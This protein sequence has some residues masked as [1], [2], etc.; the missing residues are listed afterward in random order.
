MKPLDHRA[1]GE[2]FVYRAVT[3]ERVVDA[4]RRIAGDEVRLGP[5]KA[6]PGG[7]ATVD[8]TGR[9]GVPEADETAAD[10]LTYTVRLPL[11]VAL[12]VKVG[13]VN[14]YRASGTIDLRMRVLTLAPLTLFID[15]DHVGP[16]DIDFRIEAKGVPA[17]LLGR[18]GDVDG[19]LRRYTA[20]F[21]NDRI[22]APDTA[23]FTRI[24]LVPLIEQFWAA[25]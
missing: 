20:E 23:R 19:E 21:V 18:A 4:V 9:I 25:L 3:P 10:P 5:I 12:E 22:S 14:R 7:R 6:G 15:I 16:H 1:F 17:R 11:D 2:A 13:T 24:D 8:A